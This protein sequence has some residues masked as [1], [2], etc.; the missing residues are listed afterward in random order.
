MVQLVPYEGLWR[1]Y[2]QDG[3]GQLTLTL[4]IRYGAYLISAMTLLISLAGSR[5][6]T[7]I[8]Y[9]LHQSRLG[10]KTQ[11]DPVHLQIQT[12]LRNDVTPFSAM[13][14]AFSL[15]RAWGGK[16]L[17]LEKRLVPLMCLA[18]LLSVLTTVAGILASSMA[19][20]SE[21]AIRI[22]AMPEE[23]GSWEFNW[24]KLH[25]LYTEAARNPLSHHLNAIT[26]DAMDARAYAK[27]FYSD[28]KPLSAASSK[29]PVEKL[30]YTDTMEPCPFGGKNRCLSNN[31]SSLN[32]S[33][34]W[35]TGMLDSHTHLGVNARTEDRVNFRK[36]VTCSPVNVDDLVTSTKGDGIVVNELQKLLNVSFSI[37][38]IF[39][40]NK[41]A[42]NGYTATGAFYLGALKSQGWAW[43][44]NRA[45][46]DLSL[47]LISQNS[48][49]YPEPV[50]DPLFWANGSSI[51]RDVNGVVQ[52]FG[53]NDFN[54]LACL[55]QIQLCNPRA[56]KCTNITDS[57]TALRET[58]ALELNIKQRM[59]LHRTA[60][61]LGLGNIAS[62]GPQSLGAAGLLARDRTYSDTLS[63]SLP[64]DQWQKE[65]TLWFETGLALL[66]AHFIRFLGRIDLSSPA[67]YGDFLIYKP[68]AD[69]PLRPELDAARTLCHNQKI[70]TTGRLQNF[71][72]VDLILVFAL[73]LCVILTSLL[74]ERCV[75]TG[76][77]HWVTHTGQS[78]QLTWEMDGKFWLLHIAL[79]SVGVGPWRL[80]GNSMD[81][82]I[83]VADESHLL[84]GPT[85]LG[86]EHF[87][88]SNKER[89]AQ[90]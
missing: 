85:E 18:A 19:T 58:E 80:G 22:L 72:C 49:T 34:A 57:V 73:S 23:C 8:A 10:H 33:M 70:A 64:P 5:L 87:Y 71:R 59:T 37:P 74:L 15:S 21:E 82:S 42:T 32:I 20:R 68:L 65:A 75:K 81:S 69:L 46:T 4:P 27:E 14:D 86:A 63:T 44:F 36:K 55:E 17:S 51:Y 54:I 38:L 47:C 1:D 48:V 7:I 12:L 40:S 26:K 60:M 16:L 78:R 39:Q 25:S 89:S 28:T 11:F 31:T 35:D 67:M 6:W 62:L 45:H 53:N 29:F 83:P 79:G 66:Q 52:Y 56:G 77:R 41:L 76:R 3:L 90:I 61:L 2:S 43:P 24:T 50:Y 9:G 84:N 13:K 30:P 88:T